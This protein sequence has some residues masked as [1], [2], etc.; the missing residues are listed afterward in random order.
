[1]G[2]NRPVLYL[3]TCAII[4]AYRVKCWLQLVERYELHTVRNVARNWKAGIP[5]IQ[6]TSLS[7]CNKSMRGW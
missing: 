1:M 7:I 4:E 3:D 2:T 5:M 6:I